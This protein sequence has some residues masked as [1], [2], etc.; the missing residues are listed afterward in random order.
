MATTPITT[1]MVIL[2]VIEMAI[3]VDQDPDPVMGDETIG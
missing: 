3:T 2:I 1:V